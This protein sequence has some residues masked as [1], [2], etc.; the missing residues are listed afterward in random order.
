M[1]RIRAGRPYCNRPHLP[2]VGLWWGNNSVGDQNSLIPIK[3]TLG[4]RAYNN[5]IT[6]P[7]IRPIHGAEARRRADDASASSVAEGRVVVRNRAAGCPLLGP[8]VRY[9]NDFQA[10][11]GRRRLQKVMCGRDSC[12]ALL[13]VGEERVLR[14]WRLPL[15]SRFAGSAL[16]LSSIHPWAR[17]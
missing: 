8:I 2:R 7:H 15:L 11:A 9:R 12:A 13:D 17:A 5:N 10:A 1:P 3:I 14:A 6:G 16:A 4:V